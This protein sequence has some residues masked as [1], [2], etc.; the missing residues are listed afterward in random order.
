[1]CLKA[2]APT[3]TQGL[4]ETTAGA[5]CG[6]GTA[7]TLTL[8]VQVPEAPDPSHWASHMELPAAIPP[9]VPTPQVLPEAVHQEPGGAAS[10]PPER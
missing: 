7:R 10:S 5:Q 6:D 3:A 2:F 8:K 1:M 9:N 4:H